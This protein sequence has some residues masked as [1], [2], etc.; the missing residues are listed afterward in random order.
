M[1]GSR[2]GARRTAAIIDSQSVKTTER[3]RGYDGGKKIK[4]RK[5]HIAV[6]VEGFPIVIVVHE[7]S[8]QDRDGVVIRAM[9]EKAPTVI[10][11]WADGGY[12]G[13]KLALQEMGLADLVEIVNKL[14]ESKGF[15]V[16]PR[17]W[18]V[19]RT[20]AWMLPLVSQGFRAD[21]GEFS[22]YSWQP[23]GS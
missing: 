3:A 16:I 17:R 13:P 4:G 6:D 12:Q 22:G 5:R 14:K 21:T 9:L 2:R 15:T 7:A 8:V 20:F 23:A 18:V 11:L 10:R 19:E 1:H